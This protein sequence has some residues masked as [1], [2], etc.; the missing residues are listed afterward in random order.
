MGAYLN[1]L[2]VLGLDFGII[3][4]KTPEFCKQ[5]ESHKDWI[6]ARIRISDYPQL[7]QP[8]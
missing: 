7:K 3:N 8:A 1:A 5:A 6:P 2:A 4:S